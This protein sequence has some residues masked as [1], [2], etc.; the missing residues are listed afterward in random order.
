[1]ATNDNTPVCPDWV[2]LN[3]SNV[4]VAKDRGW[5]KTYT[6]FTSQIQSSL[7]CSPRYLPVLGVGTVEIPTKQSSRKSGVANHGHLHLKQVLHVPD[8]ICNVIGRSLMTSDGYDVQMRTSKRSKGVIKDSQ[9]KSMALLNHNV[10]LYTIT[11]R[12]RP[13]G[14][15]LGPHVFWKNGMYMISCYWVHTEEKRCYWEPSEEQKWLDYQAGYHINDLESESESEP[16]GSSGASSLSA[17]S[18]PPYTKGEK[19]YLKRI[20]GCE[21]EFLTENH[22]DFWEE[23]HR[24]EGRLILRESIRE[25][26]L[27]GEM[28]SDEESDD[29]EEAS[30]EEESDLDF[31]QEDPSVFTSEELK[32]ICANYKDSDAFMCSYGLDSDDYWDRMDAKI[33]V[34][35]LVSREKRL[36]CHGTCRCRYGGFA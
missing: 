16:I 33:I 4:H 29:D 23:S 10:S 6:P 8:F 18:N 21:S 20:W 36:K 19:R 2:F 28:P 13:E 25:P 14:P 11:V 5:F 17:G 24:Q 27:N 7:F 15:K 26:V 1:M 12:N 9:G 32:W 22:L 35:E 30:E 34:N 3:N 31:E